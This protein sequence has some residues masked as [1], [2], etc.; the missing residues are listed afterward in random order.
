MGKGTM[1]VKEMMDALQIGRS[2]AYEIV[3]AKCFPSF[4]IGRKILIS[5]EGLEE[6]I[7]NGGTAQDENN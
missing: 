2:K 5:R 1:T 6:W 7:R 3:N 4:R